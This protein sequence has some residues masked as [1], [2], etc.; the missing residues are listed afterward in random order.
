MKLRETIREL[1]DTTFII[2]C[3]ANMAYASP[4][5]E[6]DL[7]RKVDGRFKFVVVK[8]DVRPPSSTLRTNNSRAIIV[9]AGTRTD[10]ASKASMVHAM[11]QLLNQGRIFFHKQFISTSHGVFFEGF[12]D[13]REVLGRQLKA[14][15]RRRLM[16]PRGQEKIK[17]TRYQYEG[18]EDD[19]FCMGL[20]LTS[21][22]MKRCQEIEGMRRVLSAT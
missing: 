1:Y 17:F 20:M 22:T 16:P 8:D 9:T 2:N 4:S 18:A 11:T 7:P 19:D 15:R 3:E 10:N 14:F 13:L 6:Y 21:Y 5:L 12:E